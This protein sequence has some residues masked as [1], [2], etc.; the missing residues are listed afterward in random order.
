VLSLPTV[1]VPSDLIAAG[2]FAARAESAETLGSAE[3]LLP[4]ADELFDEPPP[5]PVITSVALARAAAVPSARRD[6]KRAG[7]SYS[8]SGI[9]TH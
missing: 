7:T 3:P 2:T 4:F 1:I 5:Q 8:F 9:E 6:R